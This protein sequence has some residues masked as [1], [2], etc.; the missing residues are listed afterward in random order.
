MAKVRLSKQAL[1]KER[2]GLIAEA[3]E[4]LKGYPEKVRRQF[5]FLLKAA[6][7]GTIIQE[8]HNYWID[9]R[10]SYKARR[11]ILEFGNR[12]G[13]QVEIEVISDARDMSRLHGAQEI[14]R[15]PDTEVMLSQLKAGT[16][17]AEFLNSPQPLFRIPREGDPR[18][19]EKVRICLLGTAS[20]SP[21]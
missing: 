4:A 8:D 20:D 10:G 21:A 13:Q 17:M 14:P 18:R 15:T 12:F 6:K 16:E 7:A 11:V 9:Q 3:R 1:A 19:D 5:E 2:E